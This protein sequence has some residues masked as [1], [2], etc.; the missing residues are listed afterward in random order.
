M[1]ECASST[2][3]NMVANSLFKD[4]SDSLSSDD[5]SS[6]SS[7]STSSSSSSSSEDEPVR[8]TR[9]RD[10]LPGL[11]RGGMITGGRPGLTRGGLVPR[12]DSNMSQS[13]RN[14]MALASTGRSSRN[15]MVFEDTAEDDPIYQRMQ[16]L[17]VLQKQ[18]GIDKDTAFLAEHDKKAEEKERLMAMTPEERIAHQQEQLNKETTDFGARLRELRQK[19]SGRKL[20][21]MLE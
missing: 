4:D 21:A 17:L 8:A 6:F 11:T 1:N 9:G 12:G 14:L 16:A 13:R 5:D 2:T 15:L 10:G 18:L 20:K 7:L 3:T 19:Q